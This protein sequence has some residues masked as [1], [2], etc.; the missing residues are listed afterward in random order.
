[1]RTTADWLD[2][3]QRSE[4]AFRSWQR[5]SARIVDR[6]N[7]EKERSAARDGLMTGSMMGVFNILWSNV[8][9]QRPSIF[10]QLPKITAARRFKDQD[11]LGRVA[12]QVLERAVNEE[13]EEAGLKQTMN[14]VVLDVLLV[15][16]GVP[17]VRY[18]TKKTPPI[19]LQDAGPQGLLDPKGRPVPPNTPGLM[20][21]GKGPMLDPGTQEQ[22]LFVDYVHWRDFFHSLDRNWAE[23]QR[24]GWVAR[25]IAMTQG[26]GEARFGARFKKV[27]LSLTSRSAEARG[28]E[29]AA[30]APMYDNEG[31]PAAKYAAVY[32]I[33]DRSTMRRIQIAQG[34]DQPL[35][36]VEDPYKL[37]HF[38]P[39][40]RPAYSTLS[41]EDLR[42]TQ[43]Y[44]QYEALADELDDI[45]VRIDKIVRTL[46]VVGGYDLA[47]EGLAEMMDAKDGSMIGI[48]N[49][50]KMMAAGGTNGAFQF[51]PIQPAAETLAGL[52]QAREQTKQTLYEVSGISDVIRGQVDPREKA[53]QSKIKANYAGQRLE[54]RRRA[55]EYCSR[56]IGRMLVEMMAELY[57]PQLLRQKSGFDF[58]PEVVQARERWQQEQQRVQ[59][60]YE[61]A[62]QA[63]QQPPQEQSGGQPGVDPQTG[64][65][66]APAAPQPPPQPPPPPPPDPAEGIWTQ[67]VELIRDEKMRGFRID[68]ETDSTIELDSGD[69]MHK[70]T[71]MLQAAGSFLSNVLPVI[72]V[73]PEMTGP[74]SELLMFTLRGMKTARPLESK[75]EEAVQQLDQK[76]KQLAEQPPQPDPEQQAKAEKLKAETQVL[77]QRGQVEAQKAQLDAQAKQTE[78]QTAG[79]QAQTEQKKA[80]AEIGASAQKMQVENL[81]AQTEIEAKRQELQQKEEKHRIEMAILRRQLDHDEDKAEVDVR[82]AEADVEK[83]KAQAK[84]AKRVDT[85]SGNR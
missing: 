17:W 4:R 77:Q 66:V 32:E 39:C 12:A 42:P 76:Q 2:A 25:R 45:T 74:V 1:M 14:A 40:P 81:K 9:T 52:Y 70:R 64:Q 57:D 38:F 44:L 48:A 28:T 31:E 29:G 53:T 22:K 26:E 36:V 79:A 82:K 51:F 62:L 72:Q 47:L 37:Q 30:D 21:T 59:Q 55:V 68:V 23:V 35:E 84:N 50:G 3:L 20:M 41:N 67:V 65:P 43:D 27:Q 85:A 61:Q 13:A 33:W 63:A 49:F 10:S 18:E 73:S 75:F 60:E 56:D 80:Q 69:E 11:P 24:I 15:G 6:Y 7:L 78:L 16:R 71:E 5:T 8:E 19:P 46:K 58:I 83:A 54:Q 34:L